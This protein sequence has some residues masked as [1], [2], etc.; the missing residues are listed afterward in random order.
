LL[1]LLLRRV[2]AGLFLL[3]ALV[4][5][6]YALF[7]FV[8][9]DHL[10]EAEI[11]PGVAPQAVEKLRGRPLPGFTRWLAAA[12]AGDWGTS[13]ISRQPVAALLWPRAVRTL[14]LAL[15]SLALAWTIA[16]VW[17]CWRTVKRS[18]FGAWTGGLI[19]GALVAAPDL[20]IALGALWLAIESPWF[21]TSG[22][23]LLCWIALTLGLLPALTRHAES[24]LGEAAVQ[25]FVQ[26]AR[27]AGVPERRIAL[28]WMLPAA[29]PPLIALAGLGVSASLSASLIVETVL[30]WPGLGPLLLESI[31]GRDFPVILAAVVLTGGVTLAGSLAADIVQVLLDRRIRRNG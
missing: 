6:C 5:V 21:A 16:I 28:L 11:D 30:G 26:A 15:T 24:A 7:Q 13:M 12:A 29:A 2:A 23:F 3:A 8:P 22:D 18:A 27:L 4:V 19:V 1:T 25:P 10:T 9:G 31:L 20:L 14:L 17:A